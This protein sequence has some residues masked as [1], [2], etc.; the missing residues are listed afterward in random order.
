MH[1]GFSYF[2]GI[3]NV[4]TYNGNLEGISMNARATVL[5]YPGIP[6]QREFFSPAYET[7]DQINS[8]VPDFRTLLYW[9][10]EI[11]SESKNK[12]TISFYSS[13]LPGKY[14]ASIMGITKNGEPGSQL[15]YFE[16]KS[17]K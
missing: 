15:V 2:N 11:K 8:P 3:V 10:P 6:E 14:V 4:T 7:E 12:Q 1:L 17:K 13:D 9:S 16:V 5:D